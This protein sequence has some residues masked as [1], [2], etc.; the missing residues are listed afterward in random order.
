ME[1]CNS[2]KMGTWLCVVGNNKKTSAFPRLV[3]A[4]QALVAW[5]AMHSRAMTDL[6]LSHGDS[7]SEPPNLSTQLTKFLWVGCYHASP[8]L[9]LPQDL[10]SGPQANPHFAAIPFSLEPRQAAP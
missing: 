1:T 9:Q 3:L 7:D 4:T 5:P 2:F 8:M 6:F 10:C